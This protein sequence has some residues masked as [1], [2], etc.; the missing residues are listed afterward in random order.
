M[1]TVAGVSASVAG[2]AKTTTLRS[3]KTAAAD[4]RPWSWGR[5]LAGATIDDVSSSLQTAEPPHRPR[6]AGRRRQHV[7]ISSLLRRAHQPMR[8]SSPSPPAALLLPGPERQVER[9]PDERHRKRHRQQRALPLAGLRVVPDPEGREERARHKVDARDV[10]E[11]ALEED[12]PVRLPRLGPRRELHEEATQPRGE[13]V[14][15]SGRAAAVM[16]R[17]SGGLGFPHR[18]SAEAEAG[19]EEEVARELALEEPLEELR[20]KGRGGAP[21]AR[22]VW[23]PAT[24]RGMAQDSAARTAPLPL[25]LSSSCVESSAAFA[26]GCLRRG[27]RRQ[28]HV[29]PRCALVLC[30]RS[31]RPVTPPC[32]AAG[33]ERA[34]A[35]QSAMY[36]MSMN[37]PRAKEPVRNGHAGTYGGG[38]SSVQESRS[39]A[40]K[41]RVQGCRRRDGRC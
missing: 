16:C 10:D 37:A 22:A 31:C 36:G 26:L 4:R 12:L 8:A 28:R 18:P 35:H 11:A 20:A 40:A 9:R 15:V 39:T 21:S 19:G 29:R 3:R 33:S 30:E 5:E 7:D 38:R 34:A 23:P 14:G 2:T 1:R 32:A 41:A 13:R 6:R 24:R 25:A 17:L 27:A